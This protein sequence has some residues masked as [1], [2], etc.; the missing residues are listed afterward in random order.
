MVV[1]E[2]ETNVFDQGK[3]I[4]Y[5]ALKYVLYLYTCL[6]RSMY[7]PIDGQYSCTY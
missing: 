4:S 7:N 3:L 5:L 6:I 2:K 1:I